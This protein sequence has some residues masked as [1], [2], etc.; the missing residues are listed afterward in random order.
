MF[1]RPEDPQVLSELNFY[2]VFSAKIIIVVVF[3]NVTLPRKYLKPEQNFPMLTR[4]K[5]NGA[6]KCLCK[7]KCCCSDEPFDSAFISVQACFE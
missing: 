7:N 3:Q 2:V 6:E 4:K 5:G 1:Q